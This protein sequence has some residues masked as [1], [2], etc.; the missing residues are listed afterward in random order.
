LY[1]ILVNEER[2][3]IHIP[4]KFFIHILA[5]NYQISFRCF[6][7]SEEYQEGNANTCNLNPSNTG[8]FEYAL[9]NQ[10]ELYSIGKELNS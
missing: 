8:K 5:E 1:L 4:N 9:D 6:F 3:F 10:F 7:A 2:L